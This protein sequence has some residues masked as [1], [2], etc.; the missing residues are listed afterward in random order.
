MPQAEAIPVSSGNNGLLRIVGNKEIE[1]AQK[2][3]MPKPVEPENDL[4]NFAGRLKHY[5]GEAKRNKLPME[6]RLLSCDRQVKGEYEP[7]KLSAIK[8]KGGSEIFMM[9]TAQKKRDLRSWLLDILKPTGPS[10]RIFTLTPTPIPDLPQE[11]EQEIGHRI[12]NGLMQ[13]LTMRVAATGEEVTDDQ[14]AEMMGAM[15][16]DAREK[17]KVAIN[18][19]AAEITDK[20][21]RKIDDQ[22]VEGKWYKIFKD[23]VDDFCS[24]PSA[25]MKVPVIK[26]KKRKKYTFNPET[27]RM[28]LQ[29]VRQIVAGFARVSPWDFYPGPDTTIDDEGQVRGYTWERHRFS[30]KELS[31]MIGTPGYKS[32]KIRKILQEY[33]SGGIRE[34]M[35]TD[36]ERKRL[37]GMP[38]Y[39]TSELIDVLEFYGAI[40]GKLL[41]EWGVDPKRVTDPDID[42]EVTAMMC[43][44]E[45]IKAIVEPDKL[46]RKPYLISSYEKVPGSIWG[47]SL[48]E[49]IA[50]TQDMC[51][52]S[53]RSLHE[54]MSIASGPMMEIDQSRCDVDAIEPWMVIR[55]TQDQMNSG[56][57]VQFYTTSMHAN[58]LMAVYAQFKK[59]ADHQSGVPAFAHGDTQ[60]G[61]AGNTS[62]GLSM[63]MSAA[64]RGI[65]GS[66]SNL[67]LDM[68][69][70]GTE[71]MYDFNMLYDD[72]ESIK[73]DA[74]VKA[75]GSGS[76]IAK[77]QLSVRR[78]EF[79]D[80]LAGNEVEMAIIGLEGRKYQIEE[81][82]KSGELDPEKLM[83]GPAVIGAQ[84]APAGGG[85]QAEGETK[86][87]P[88]GS[89]AGGEEAKVIKNEGGR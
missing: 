81:G 89:P 46:D 54:N 31:G 87:L 23:T 25:I 56:K 52:N 8:A 21:S 14:I 33:Q 76:M 49:T 39:H 1:D 68:I 61:G 18:E 11:V 88:D 22:M 30:R 15:M 72:D 12:M 4:G 10:D 79:M 83:R 35:W 44:N 82:A 7:E 43:N 84:P 62:S 38:N 9:I 2:A 50:D 85:G 57:A 86:L 58:E 65:K 32:D 60:V 34:W 29:V 41:L 70:E 64:A 59:E 47:I 67:D 73:G 37:E 51:N 63:M 40:Q 17:V 78:K 71:R 55:S 53:A 24:Y 75:G 20:M 16:D 6:E 66:I 19:K 74:R 80:S 69:T 26:R 5:W 45:I 77:E 42:Y 27:Q 36:S 28:E 48:A 13:E 3:A